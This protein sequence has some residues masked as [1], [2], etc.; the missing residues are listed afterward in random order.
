MQSHRSRLNIVMYAIY[1]RWRNM[2]NTPFMYDAK[3]TAATKKKRKNGDKKQPGRNPYD[4][5]QSL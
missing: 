5:G 3:L 1:L 2:A 4:E